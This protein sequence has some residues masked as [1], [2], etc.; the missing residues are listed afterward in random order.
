MI[1][2][3][4]RGTC[5]PLHLRL[6]DYF[7]FD[8]KSPTSG[9]PQKEPIHGFL[10]PFKSGP[11]PYATNACVQVAGRCCNDYGQQLEIIIF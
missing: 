8:A 5:R 9:R 11:W 4:N 1:Q 2:F 6:G 3:R 7:T 10:H